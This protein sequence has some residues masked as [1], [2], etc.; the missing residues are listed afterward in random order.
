MA[1]ARQRGLVGYSIQQCGPET[2][3]LAKCVGGIEADSPLGCSHRDLVIFF[4]S[5]PLLLR[6]FQPRRPRRLVC[7][8]LLWP[9]AGLLALPHRRRGLAGRLLFLAGPVCLFSELP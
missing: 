3:L 5:W 7:R 8:Q 1:G 9:V 2:R 6:L 4:S